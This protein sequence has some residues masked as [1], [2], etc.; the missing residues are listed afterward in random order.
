M[1]DTSSLHKVRAPQHSTWRRDRVTT[2]RLALGN[3]NGYFNVCEE[4][5]IWPEQHQ[6]TS[7]P[8]LA[9]M[10]CH[11]DRRFQDRALRMSVINFAH[12][13][14]CGSS[15]SRIRKNPLFLMAETER[16]A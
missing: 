10:R 4:G 6:M 11:Q 3:R 12:E 14:R 2:P 9:W 1:N 7:K 15:T 5:I 16:P 13:G 8:I